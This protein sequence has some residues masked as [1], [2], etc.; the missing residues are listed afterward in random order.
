MLK[1]NGKLM[2]VEWKNADLPFGPI[3]EHRVKIEAIKNN[4]NNLGLQLVDEFDA[5]QYHYGL[6]LKKL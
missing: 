3:E 4:A 6:L 1:R 5:G 2:I